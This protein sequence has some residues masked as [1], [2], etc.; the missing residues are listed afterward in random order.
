M[1]KCN[2][3]IRS[4]YCHECVPKP[5]QERP[6]MTTL[7]YIPPNIL[8]EPFELVP[9]SEI[10]IGNEVVATVPHRRNE[11][12]DDPIVE[13]NVAMLRNR[14]DFG[15]KKYGKPLD[16]IADLEACL[17]HALE[18]VLDLAN[19]VQT[20]LKKVRENGNVKS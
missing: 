7:P 15:L 5:A 9:G 6:P 17:V 12:C 4:I 11:P 3:S 18:E 14:S 8:A 1:C 20:A 16:S 10:K 19:Y 2:P 13:A